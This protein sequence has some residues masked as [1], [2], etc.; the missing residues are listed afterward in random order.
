MAKTVKDWAKMEWYTFGLDLGKLLQAMFETVYSQ[1]YVVDSSGSL[2]KRLIRASAHS[3][4]QPWAGGA[5]RIL[6]KPRAILL[7][8]V[9]LLAALLALKGRHSL[10]AWRHEQALHL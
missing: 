8:V 6:A 2:R 9:P 7:A 4:D 10:S 1:K 3:S 5:R